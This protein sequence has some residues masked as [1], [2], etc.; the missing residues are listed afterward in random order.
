MFFV[1]GGESIASAPP[2]GDGS[3]KLDADERPW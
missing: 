3:D 1:Q 2:P